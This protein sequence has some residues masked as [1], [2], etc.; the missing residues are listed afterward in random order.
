MKKKKRFNIKQLFLLFIIHSLKMS[1]RRILVF[2]GISWQLRELGFM[3]NLSG[4][5]IMD[6][7]SFFYL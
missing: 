4:S 2:Q 1:F 3:V 6:I 7:M 5:N